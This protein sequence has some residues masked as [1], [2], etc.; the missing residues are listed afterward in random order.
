MYIANITTATITLKLSYFV[1]KNSGFIVC[2]NIAGIVNPITANNNILE[3]VSITFLLK[4]CVLYF[5]PPANILAPS[6][7]NIFPITEPAIEALTTSNKPSFNAKNEIIS[8]VA[9]PKVAFKKPP[10]FG[11]V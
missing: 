7:N 11:P 4:L 6:T 8:S 10:N 3:L 2:I 1:F 5:N 9:F